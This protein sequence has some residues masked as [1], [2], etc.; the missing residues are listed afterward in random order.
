MLVGSALLAVW[1]VNEEAPNPAV[2]HTIDALESPE[3]PL[4]RTQDAETIEST[5]PP[6]TLATEPKYTL[7]NCSCVAYMREIGHDFK[8]IRTPADLQSNSTPSIGKLL[9]YTFSGYPH[10]GEILDMRPGGMFVKHRYLSKGDCI[11][12]TGFIEYKDIRGVY[13]PQPSVSD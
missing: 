3:L 7:D 12:T 9:L 5:T 4:E 1:L 13:S 6:K 10:I 11:T 8:R 2:I